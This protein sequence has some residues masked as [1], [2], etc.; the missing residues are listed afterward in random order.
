MYY[1][2]CYRVLICS[3]QGSYPIT[4]LFSEAYALVLQQG[5]KLVL[6]GHSLGGGVA[7][8]LTMM[9]YST[10]WS[11][12]IPTSLGIFRHNIKCWGYGC[13][14]CVDR[15]LAERETFIRNVVLQVFLQSVRVQNIKIEH[16]HAF[17]FGPVLFC[18]SICI[19]TFALL[20]RLEFFVS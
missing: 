9:I 2:L 14:P 1:Q 13:A 3:L 20:K 15:T 7:A 4:G 17:V 10:S 8:L 16:T 18:D 11:W 6:T 12:F 5:Y 19:H